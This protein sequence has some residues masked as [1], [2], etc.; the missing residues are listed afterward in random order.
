MG[1]GGRW[2]SSA[3]DPE[4][5]EDTKRQEGR[6]LALKEPTVSFGEKKYP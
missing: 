4:H 3:N 6:I 5:C 1:Y 2:S